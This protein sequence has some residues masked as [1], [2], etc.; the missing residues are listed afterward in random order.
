MAIGDFGYDAYADSYDEDYLWA[1]L[2]FT[3]ILLL[4]VLLNMLIAIMG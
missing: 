2:T 1:Y 3:T 4:V